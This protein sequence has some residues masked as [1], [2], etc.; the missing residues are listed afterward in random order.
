MSSIFAAGLNALAVLALA[1]LLVFAARRF[2]FLLTLFR[3]QPASA[4]APSLPPVLLL[5]PIRDESASL[6]ALFESLD[7]LEYPGELLQVLLVDDGSTDESPQLMD[8]AVKERSGWR[9]LHL[10]LNVG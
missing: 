10:P 8:R 7:G 9:A 1:V 5:I 3:P 4:P 2:V 6:S